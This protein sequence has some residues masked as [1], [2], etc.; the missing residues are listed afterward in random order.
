MVS[1]YEENYESEALNLLVKWFSKF[2]KYK[3][4]LM[5]NLQ[6]IREALRKKINLVH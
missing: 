2:L 1:Q 3:N 4:K 5:Q 6:K